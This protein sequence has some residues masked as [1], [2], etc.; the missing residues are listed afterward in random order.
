[1]KNIKK[2]TFLT[3]ALLLSGCATE[4]QQKGLFSEGYSDM[5]LGDDIYLVEYQSNEYTSTSSNTKHA[6]RRAA[7]ISKMH[8]HRYFE[9]ISKTDNSKTHTSPI[10]I[11]TQ[12]DATSQ[13]DEMSEK[14]NI[15]ISGGDTVVEPGIALKIRLLKNKT[16][17]SYDAD[18]ILGNF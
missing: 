1:M 12:T 9:V 10:S 3:L 18:A 14:S 5:K 6:L 17:N 11:D 13:L 4:Y 7:E 2:L 8:G 15:S 16:N